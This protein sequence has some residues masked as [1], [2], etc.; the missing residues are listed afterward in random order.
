MIKKSIVYILLF[1]CGLQALDAAETVSSSIDLPHNYGRLKADVGKR[2]RNAG[3]TTR[4]GNKSK[5]QSKATSERFSYFLKSLVLPG[6]G[7]YAMGNKKESLFF[8]STEVVL[9]AAAVGLNYYSGVRE[10]DYKKYARAHA[11]VNSDGKQEQYWKDL[12]NY[13]DVVA[14]NLYK[15]NIRDFGSRYENEEDYWFWDSEKSR[16]KYDGIRISSE[17]ARVYSY[18]TIGGILANHL[19]SAI[20]ASYKA[21]KI[22]PAVSTTINDDHKIE[23]KL[24]VSYHF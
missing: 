9:I 20:N 7:E 10:D 23:S 13:D 24:S 5:K 16:K 3:R 6:W 8:A 22:K 1:I 19:F 12:G 2:G 17:D 4:R 11:G 14:Y 21:G 18:Y 15:T